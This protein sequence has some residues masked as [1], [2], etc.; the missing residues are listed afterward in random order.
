MD[1]SV[2]VRVVHS[3]TDLREQ[4]DALAYAA[5]DAPQTERLSRD[6]VHRDEAPSIACQARVEDFHQ[7]WMVE[8]GRQ[9]YLAL[10]ASPRGGRGERSLTQH[11]ERDFAL[12]A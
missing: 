1:D 8:A 10:E 2:L 3:L 9:L 5:A 11:L 6:Q 4:G 7:M 12:C